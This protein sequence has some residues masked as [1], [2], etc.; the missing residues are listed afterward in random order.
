MSLV[1]LSQQ[2]CVERQ[3]KYGWEAD[4]VVE[5]VWVNPAYIESMSWSG[6]TVIK[7]QSGDKISVTEHMQSIIKSIEEAK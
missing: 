6:V 3:G 2:C 5:D 4:T 1:K 7:M